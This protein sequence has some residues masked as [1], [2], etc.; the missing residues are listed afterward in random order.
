MR[1]AYLWAGADIRRRWPSLVAVAILIAVAVGSILALVGGARRADS[2]LGRYARAVDLPEIIVSTESERAA[3]LVAK[4]LEADPRIARVEHAVGLTSIVPGP[5]GFDQNI[6]IVVGTPTSLTGGFGRPRLLAGRYPAPSSPDEI[7]VNERAARTYSFQPSQR[8]PLRAVRCE[9]GC[10]AEVVGQATI[11]GV[12]RLATDLT[13]DPTVPGIVIASPAFLAG[14]WRDIPGAAGWLGVHLRDRRDT[15]SLVDELSVRVEKGDVVSTWST[16]D[17]LQRAG[18]LQRNALLAA[19]AAVAVAGVLVVALALARHLAARSDDPLVLAALGLSPSRRRRAALLA[20]GPALVGGLAG[21]VAL[22]VAGSPLL[23]LGLVRRTDPHVGFQADVVVLGVGAAVAVT[24]VAAVALVVALRWATPAPP[25]D[26]TNRPALATR[27]AARLGLRPVPA[28]GVRLALDRGH[29]P[30][31]LPVEATL[32]VVAT[33]MA[34]VVGALVV[35]WSLVGLV[36]TPDRY[37]EPWDLTVSFRGEEVQAGAHRLAADQRVRDVAISRQGEVNL[38]AHDGETAQIATTGI[39]RLVGAVPVTVLKGRVPAEPREIA[40]ATKTMRKLGLHV[41][42]RTTASGPCGSSE[43]EVVGEVIVP[44]VGN[45]YPEDGSILTL[46]AFEQLCAV[47]LAS[48][49]DLSDTALV[50]LR[51]RGDEAKVRDEWRA[52]G[53]PVTERSKPVAIVLIDDIRVVPLLVA[54]LVA[55]LAAAATVHALVLA[56]RRRRH[57]LAVLRAL[58]LRPRQAGRII[59]WQGATLALVGIAAGLPLGLVLGRLVWTALA[60]LSRVFVYVDVNMVDLGLVVVGVA[61]LA[62]VLAI[63]PA[64]RASR[65][66]PAEA[67]RSE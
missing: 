22:A 58:G 59:R 66:R 44:D 34:T 9:V 64:H 7:V 54:V 10:P 1:A 19:A 46:D 3:E 47:D 40:L 41:G 55:V 33:A 17:V 45:N 36:D 24:A 57:D 39:A 32:L 43:T 27:L 14:R 56:V 23:P 61:V 6:F 21:G 29:G 38:R 12:A 5:M 26:S 50:G 63:W 13:G 60:H 42:D 15:A 28:T 37:G 30:T 52:A 20:I 25:S 49:F 65:L 48:G 67:L 53:L 16:L 2:A 11:V 62:G 51:D 31:R 18:H 35:R 8:V 4:P